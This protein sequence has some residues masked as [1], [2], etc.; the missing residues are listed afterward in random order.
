[1]DLKE[2]REENINLKIVEKS[3]SDSILEIGKVGFSLHA[4]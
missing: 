1:M 3:Q 4:L 2:T